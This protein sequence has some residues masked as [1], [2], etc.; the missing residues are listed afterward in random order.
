MIKSIEIKNFKSIKSKYFPLRN[1]NVMMGLNGQGKSSFIQALLLLRQA[2]Q[3]NPTTRLNLN[4][5]EISLGT[6]KDILY[7]YCKKDDK[8]SFTIQFEDKEPHL[9]EYN[10][11]VEADYFEQITYLKDLQTNFLRNN[12]G[13]S[14]FSLQFQ[15]LSA[16]RVDPKSNHP[17][18]YSE[19]VVNKNIGIYA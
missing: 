17:K 7:Q 3:N 9:L 18:N 8:L 16:S 4:G 10:Y 12:F 15:Y 1:L 13:E 2:S 5:Y 14:L 11:L 6:S 19:V